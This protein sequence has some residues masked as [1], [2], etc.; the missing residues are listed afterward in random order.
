MRVR[1]VWSTVA[2]SQDVVV[3]TFVVSRCLVFHSASAHHR[4][5]SPA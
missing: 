1:L 3:D 2:A 4:D 5:F